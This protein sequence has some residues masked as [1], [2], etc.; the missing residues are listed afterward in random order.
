MNDESSQAL[1]DTADVNSPVE[2][3][4][5]DQNTEEV[6]EAPASTESTEEVR[7]VEQ[8]TETDGESK[9]GSS[10]RIRELANENRSLKQRMAELTGAQEQSFDPTPYVPQVAPGQE[11]SPEQYRQDVARHAD[12]LV[13]LRI[14]QSE[15]VN[16]INNEA[17]QAM[18]DNPELDPDSDKFN[19]DLSESVN[20]AVEAYVKHN[21]YSASPLQLVQKMMKPYKQAL[22]KEVGQSQEQLAKQVTQSA[23]R[24]TSVHKT[25]KSAGEMS[26]SE[27]EAKLG[28]VQ[29]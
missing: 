3:P 29:A 18:R 19:K 15:A 11:V 27:L 5:T 17:L 2:S 7:A 28:I 8:T 14:K 25:E 22:A 13:T 26:I 6:V 1:N 20:E 24:P 12:S 4:T 10:S 16:R 21:P 9:K 23:P